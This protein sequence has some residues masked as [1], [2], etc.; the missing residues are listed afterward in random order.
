[1]RISNVIKTLIAGM[2]SLS[3]GMIAALTTGLV[4]FTVLTSL[5]SIVDIES[6]LIDYRFVLLTSSLAMSYMAFLVTPWCYRISCKFAIGAA[7]IWPPG[8]L[9][10]DD[11]RQKRATESANESGRLIKIDL[12]S[13]FSEIELETMSDVLRASFPNGLSPDKIDVTLGTIYSFAPTLV[14]VTLSLKDALLIS[15]RC[16]INADDSERYSATDKQRT[17]LRQVLHEGCDTSNLGG[18]SETFERIAEKRDNLSGVLLGQKTTENLNATHLVCELMEEFFACALMPTRETDTQ[19]LVGHLDVA[20]IRLIQSA[21]ALPYQLSLTELDFKG[22]RAESDKKL[23][24]CFSEINMLFT[25]RHTL[26]TLLPEH[27]SSYSSLHE[28]SCELIEEAI[29]WYNANKPESGVSGMLEQAILKPILYPL[30]FFIVGHLPNFS[31][32]AREKYSDTLKEIVNV[33]L[34]PAE[35]LGQFAMD[36]KTGQDIEAVLYALNCEL[37]RIAADRQE[38][39]P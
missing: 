10:V 35:Y 39:T 1:M 23:L 30:L 2:T 20:I 25:Y 14:T 34:D 16:H 11:T 4:F 21:L 15:I 27:S 32:D 6:D 38:A 36:W 17:V 12:D 28:N 33:H 31:H 5:F 3:L 19:R 26:F 22:T 37:D 13:D 18:T 9:R 29:G 8:T 24:A 7:P